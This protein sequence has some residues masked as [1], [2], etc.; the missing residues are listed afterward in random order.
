ML[1]LMKSG[2][3]HIFFLSNTNTPRIRFGEYRRLKRIV[4]LDIYDLHFW[5]TLK[6]VPYDS[7]TWITEFHSNCPLANG[8]VAAGFYIKAFREAFEKYDEMSEEER[9]ERAEKV[10]ERSKVCRSV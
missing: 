4:G 7:D 9:Q 5:D 10:A 2:S 6:L 1:A 8:K 3:C